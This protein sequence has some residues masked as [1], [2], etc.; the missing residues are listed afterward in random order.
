LLNYH[1]KVSFF[2]KSSTT[3]YG[4]DRF[5]VGVSTTDTEVSSFT[6]ISEGTYVETTDEWTEYSYDL[7]QYAGQDVYISINCVSFDAFAFLVDDFKVVGSEN[8]SVNKALASQ[9]M[10][11]PNPTM[12]KVNL[13]NSGSI[14]V[15]KVDVRDLNGRTVQSLNFNSEPSLEI[16]V[17]SL[18]AG[19][20]LLHITTNEGFLT[21]KIIKK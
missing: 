17:S 6:V 19:V 9:F 7:N 16:D 12:D 11:F 15:S 4:A 10:L 21:K 5:K 20:Y 13:T 18:Q 3:E 14:L 8:A 1:N 2:A